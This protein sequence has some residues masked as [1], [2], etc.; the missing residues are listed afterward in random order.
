MS[1]NILK[2]NRMGYKFPEIRKFLENS[3]P[4]DLCFNRERNGSSDF[5]DIS[6]RPN[7]N[8]VAFLS[9]V[10]LIILRQPSYM[11]HSSYKNLLS[12]I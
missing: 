7:I 6:S 2:I 10:V 5:T 12:N 3:M 1:P 8:T 4:D 9:A 11:K